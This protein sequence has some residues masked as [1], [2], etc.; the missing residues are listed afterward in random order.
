MQ[1]AVVLA[2][3]LAIS[4]CAVTSPIQPAATSKSGFDGVAFRG[5]TVNIKPET[6]GNPAYR[7]FIQGGTGFVSM[8]TVRDEAEQRATAFCDRQGKVMESLT[9]TTATPPFILGNFP[10]IE[11]VFD[12]VQRTG[13][14]G[15][16]D[17]YAKLAKLKQLLDSGA[18]TQ[19]E[20]EREKGK[21]LSQP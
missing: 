3:T 21:V 7:V 20:F 1:K 12:C 10:R 6:A 8:Q 2:S 16:D 4:A 11:I 18:L 13:S 14:S 9:E 5:Q 15:T 17:K 19:E